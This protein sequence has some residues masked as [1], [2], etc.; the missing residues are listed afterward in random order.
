MAQ[1]AHGEDWFEI[2]NGDVLPVNLAG[3]WLSDTPATPKIT[4]IPLLS[5]IA[6]KG[7]ADFVAD[8]SNDGN[9]HANFKLSGS[10][11]NL[12]SRPAREIRCSTRSRSRVAEATS[13]A[14]ACPTARQRC[15]IS[16]SPNRAT[17]ATGCPRPVVINE[18]LTNSLLPLEDSIELYNP[19]GASVDVGG[20]WLSDDKTARQKF[21]IAGDTTIPA[22]GYLTFTESQFNAGANPFQLSSLGDEIVL[23]ATSAGTE[24]GLRAQ[25]STGVSAEN[26]SYIRVLTGSP[27]G[28]W[29]PE[30]W[31]ATARTPG[32][33]NSAP[34]VTP[35]HHQRNPLP[36]ARSSRPRGQHAR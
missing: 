22:G 15:K 6:G 33:A 24:T 28:S 20:W 21:Q 29:K 2:Y 16:R 36:P 19:T 3:L 5:Y 4:Q 8:G 25:V 7:F 32:V 17:P 31:P 12:C 30:F 35:R 13:H 9:N 14:D 23:T 1:P 18:A 34:I 11:D 10:G 27:A 26:V